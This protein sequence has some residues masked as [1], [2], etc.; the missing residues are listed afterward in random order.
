[1]FLVHFDDTFKINCSMLSDPIDGYFEDYFIGTWLAYE[2]IYAVNMWQFSDIYIS[3]NIML[4]IILQLNKMKM[5][6]ISHHKLCIKFKFLS[7]SFWMYKNV[8]IF[9]KSNAM[10]ILLKVHLGFIIKMRSSNWCVSFIAYNLDTI[11]IYSVFN[12]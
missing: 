10:N 12:R 7:T 2:T 8:N 4:L 5:K 1:M 3:K 11:W 9:I 6:K